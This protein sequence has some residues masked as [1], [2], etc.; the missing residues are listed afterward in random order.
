MEFW[1]HL[2]MQLEHKGFRRVENKKN[3][4]WQAENPVLYLICL[5]DGT[6][7]DW[8]EENMTFADF[9]G[10]MEN[11]VEDFHC[12]RVVALSVLVDNQEGALP[13]DSVETAFQ[14]YDNTLYRVFWQFSPETGRLTAAQGQ[15][16]QLLG[17]EKLLRAAAEGREPEVLVLRDTKEQ[18]T[19]VA[20][21]LIFVI[22]AALLA[23][24]MLS[25]QREEILSAYG[26]SREGILAGEYYRFFTCMFLHAGLI[27]LAS[28]SIYLYYFGVRAERLLG[29]GKFLV[30]Y[31][32]SGLCG[33]IFSVL[34]SGNAG[35]SIGASGAI[36]G[37]LGA[38]LLLTKKRGARYTGMNYS[39]ML[40]LAATAIGIG[41]LQEGV[42]NFAHIGGFLGGIAVFSLLLRKK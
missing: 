36:Y 30:L 37:L 29:T 22:C 4:Y 16:T 34:F 41:F 42:D 11:R 26:L 35:V 28:N 19:P 40:L 20:T 25:G 5:L 18:K 13:V 3:W 10:K 39:T 38:M 9:A 31:L 21:A 32:V 2:Q 12:T 15:P 8:R 24:C 6:A 23:W 7:E 33:G 27:H 14:A 1:N 17:V